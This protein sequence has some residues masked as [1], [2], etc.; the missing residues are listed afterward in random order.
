M[1]D[2][3]P[4]PFTGSSA[5]VRWRRTVSPSPAARPVWE[6]LETHERVVLL[7]YGY[8]SNRVLLYPAKYPVGT[9]VEF[10]NSCS[11]YLHGDE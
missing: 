10:R 8:G 11:V 4:P 6:N 1:S 5:V 3:V 7:D 9:I 2:P